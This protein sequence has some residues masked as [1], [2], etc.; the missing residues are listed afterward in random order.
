MRG[1]MERLRQRGE[2]IVV[3]REVDA[4]HELAAVT[5]AIQK[6]LDKPVL[7]LNVTGTDMPVLSNIYGS[8]ERLAEILGIEPHDFCR[9]WSKLMERGTFAGPYTRD[10][11]MPDDLHHGRM[12]D[13]PLL[14]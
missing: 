8:R 3:E 2:L 11:D 13:L 14:T 1:Y 12:S 7:F 6:K 5:D 9:E 10:I 4:K